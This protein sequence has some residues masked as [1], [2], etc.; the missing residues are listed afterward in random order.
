MRARAE[1]YKFSGTKIAVTRLLPRRKMK[2]FTFLVLGAY[3]CLCAAQPVEKLPVLIPLPDEVQYR[4]GSKPLILECYASGKVAG[5]KYSWKR[6]GKELNWK[7]TRDNEGTLIIREPTKDDEGKYQ[8]FAESDL[9]IASSRVIDVKRAYI[10]LEKVVPQ[11]HTPVEGRVYKLECNVPKAYPKPTIIWVRESENGEQKPVAS[12]RLTVSP[13]GTLYFS[14]VTKEDTDEKIKY[15]CLGETPALDDHAVLAEHYITNVVEDKEPKTNDVI[16]Q[17]VSKDV[18]AKIGDV[19][20]LYC[21]YGG[22]PLAHPDWFKDGTNVNNSP[23]DRVTRYNKSVGK[24]LLIKETWLED[25]GSYTCSVDNEVGKAQTHTMHLSVVSAPKFTKQPEAM[26]NVKK[27]QDV[28]IP[29]QVSGIPLPELVWT[30]NTAP[31]PQNDRILLHQS[32]EGNTTVAD[33][34]IKN[35]QENDKGYYGCRGLNENGDVYAETLLYVS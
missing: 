21:I 15:V 31:L 1:L 25:E 14:N 2:V 9:G 10:D 24:R 3:A 33:L 23:A 34:T 6:D 29:C 35:V 20:L 18:V 32:N 12:Q 7:P 13:E 28:T 8:C 27:G 26:V 16:E 5:V 22:V 11:K 4:V 17:Y 30:W 19:T